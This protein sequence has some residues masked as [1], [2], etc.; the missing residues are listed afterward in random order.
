M[1]F[2]FRLFTRSIDRYG[3]DYFLTRIRLFTFEAGIRI[4]KN[5]S[6]YGDFI[7]IDAVWNGKYHRIM[8][9]ELLD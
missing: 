1:E 9:T 4:Y 2:S 7:H 6:G 8:H 5:E 3:Y